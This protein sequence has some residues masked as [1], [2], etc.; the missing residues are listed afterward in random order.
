MD[1]YYKICH[2]SNIKTF[3]KNIQWV[4]IICH[5]FLIITQVKVNHSS[6]SQCFQ[7][8]TLKAL[9]NSLEWNENWKAV[10]FFIRSNPSFFDLTYMLLQ[11][12]CK[13]NGA[14]NGLK[15]KKGKKHA[16]QLYMVK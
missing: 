13:N 9:L 1:R 8:M 16:K 10:L 11:N 4:A 12:N 3:F 6:C 15:Q 5:K 2:S 7:Y 14:T